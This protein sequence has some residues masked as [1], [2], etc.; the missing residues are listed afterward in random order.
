MTVE[1]SGESLGE[2]SGS[3]HGA[4][5]PAVL[6]SIEA[7]AA[8]AAELLGKDARISATGDVVTRP[9]PLLAM[10]GR[11]GGLG[12]VF[13]PGA[14]WDKGRDLLKPF[15]SRF[16]TTRNDLDVVL[17]LRRAF[18]GKRPV[19]PDESY[20]HCWEKNRQSMKVIRRASGGY[21]T[22]YLA[23][24]RGKPRAPSTCNALHLW[25]HRPSPELPRLWQVR[26]RCQ[27]LP[28][29]TTTGGRS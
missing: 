15:T 6:A 21:C 10:V 4:E 28:T 3:T 25:R 7:V 11:A 19:S 26:Y 27:Q 13:V 22:D 14:V 2:S 29:R 24:F 9:H 5:T 16:A 23:Q 12:V 8:R 1:S 17:D 20:I 18:F